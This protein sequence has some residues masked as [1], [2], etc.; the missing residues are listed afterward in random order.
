MRLHLELRLGSGSVAAKKASLY[1]S[2]HHSPSFVYFP[3]YSFRGLAFHL[4]TRNYSRTSFP[5]RLPHLLYTDIFLPIIQLG[6]ICLENL[7]TRLRCPGL[8]C[9]RKLFPPTQHSLTVVPRFFCI[10][11]SAACDHRT[12]RSLAKTGAQRSFHAF[13]SSVFLPFLELPV[14][15]L[16]WALLPRPSSPTPDQLQHPVFRLARRDSGGRACA[17]PSQPLFPTRAHVSLS[18]PSLPRPAT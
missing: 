7:K 17:T 4:H 11:G 5:P 14:F 3:L 18:F 13:V 6:L 12:P 15:F 10:P 8:P 16:L 2:S 1:I 9:R